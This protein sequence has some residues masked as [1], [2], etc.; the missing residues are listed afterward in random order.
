MV[1]ISPV[2]KLEPGP[3]SY[4][5][6]EPTPET[7]P[8][9][10]SSL[11]TVDQPDGGPGTAFGAAAARAATADPAVWG[12]AGAAANAA[13]RVAPAAGWPAAADADPVLVL[14]ATIGAAAAT[15]IASLRPRPDPS[16]APRKG[17]LARP[18]KTV[19]GRNLRLAA[20]RCGN[21]PV[22]KL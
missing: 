20:A 22:N 21:L 6:W 12:A 4:I 2:P 8:P 7:A 15:S 18:S 13:G 16:C 10:K 14:S 11:N 9:L 1:S 17:F 5:H 3:V 19:I